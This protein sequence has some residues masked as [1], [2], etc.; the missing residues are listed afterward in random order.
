MMLAIEVQLGKLTPVERPV[1]APKT[2]Q[3]LIKVMAAGVNRPDV[4]QRKG[5]YPPA[6]R[7]IGHSGLGNCWHRH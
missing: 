5:L 1:T 3:A 2:C 6:V 4:M 7:R